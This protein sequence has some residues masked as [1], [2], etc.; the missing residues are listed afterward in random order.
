MSIMKKY[1]VRLSSCGNIDIGQNPDKPL[2]G[3]PNG[4]YQFD[5]IEECQSAV[6]DYID[7]HDLGAGNWSGGNVYEN[8]K[9]IGLISYNGRFWGKDTKYGKER[10]VS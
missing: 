7:K 1:E 3:V 9:Y 10:D 5:S 4:D 6:R 8:G 2:F